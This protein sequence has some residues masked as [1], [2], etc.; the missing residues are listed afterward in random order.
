MV[1][2]GAAISALVVDDKPCLT[3]ILANSRQSV[4]AG[5][6]PRRRISR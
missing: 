6:L 3:L 4:Q 5:W 2:Y 1:G